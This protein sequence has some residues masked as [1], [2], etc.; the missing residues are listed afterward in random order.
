MTPRRWI[1]SLQGALYLATGLWP[2]V[3]IRSFE[4]VTGP[5]CERWLVKTTGALIAATGVALL[6]G[7][8]EPRAR[9]TLSLGVGIAAVL[10]AADVIYVFKGRIAPIYLLDAAVEVAL[11]GASLTSHRSG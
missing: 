6:I 1:S 10:A 5:K 8:K 7:A 3:H 2:I 4:A 11:A 9:A